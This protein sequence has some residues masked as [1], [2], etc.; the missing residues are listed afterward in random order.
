MILGIFQPVIDV[1]SFIYGILQTIINGI[2][3][4]VA[5]IV[6]LFDMIIDITR[7]IPDPLYTLFIVFVNVYFTIA[8]YKIFRKG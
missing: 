1:F 4:C 3:G 5:I 2:Y 6:N 8:V 7:I